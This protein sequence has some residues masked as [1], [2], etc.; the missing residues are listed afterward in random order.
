MPP[1]LRSVT[2]DDNRDVADAEQGV[3]ILTRTDC[4]N[5][6]GYQREIVKL[7]DEGKLDGMVLGKIELDL[8]GAGR[9][10]R[11]N[12]WLR[13]IEYLP[14]TLL[15][16]HGT[17]TDRFAASKGSYLVERIRAAFEP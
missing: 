13:E 17:I 14:Y 10:K 12:P 8:P 2:H 1:L 3:L 5:C 6:A 11:D 9:F 15:Y 4:A 7:G 16:D